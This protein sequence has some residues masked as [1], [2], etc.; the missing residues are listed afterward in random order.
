[1]FS[2]SHNVENLESMEVNVKAPVSFER[3]IDLGSMGNSLNPPSVISDNKNES[4]EDVN[5][6]DVI[7]DG[8]QDHQSS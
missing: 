8:S 2:K 3:D 4:G 6:G 1:M 7:N 5:L